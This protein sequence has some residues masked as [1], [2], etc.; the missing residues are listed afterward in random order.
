MGFD[1]DR[2]QKQGLLSRRGKEFHDVRRIPTPPPAPYR[3]HGSP[4]VSPASRPSYDHSRTASPASRLSPPPSRRGSKATQFQ[5]QIP[6][7]TQGKS[8]SQNPAYG[9]GP[10]EAVRSPTNGAAAAIARVALHLPTPSVDIPIAPQGRPLP[11]DT[12]SPK[13]P[14]SDAHWHR[15][16]PE[17]ASPVST[18]SLASRALQRAQSDLSQ[19]H[20]S[21]IRALTP[22][23]RPQRSK[24]ELRSPKGSRIT[25]ED[26]FGL[27]LPSSRKG[28]SSYRVQRGRQQRVRDAIDATRAGQYLVVFEVDRRAAFS[29]GKP[30]FVAMVD[31]RQ[32]VEKLVGKV[33]QR[34][35]IPNERKLFLITWDK[36]DG[37][38]DTPRDRTIETLHRYHAVPDDGCLTFWCSDRPAG[39][40]E[41]CECSIQ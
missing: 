7:A 14:K 32:T 35:N 27:H 33:R 39:K 38:L 5:G 12:G 20:S 1:D 21:R 40:K 8:L 41:W 4:T 29:G 3:S 11:L 24:T 36:D 19:Q 37:E 23:P 9:R 6:V 13:S 2:E 17:A 28:Q 30:G 25:P 26:V 31:G 34:L 16:P 18:A 22:P 10:L 15:A